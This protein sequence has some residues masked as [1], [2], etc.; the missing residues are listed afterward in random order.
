[1][2][3]LRNVVV[4]L[5]CSQEVAANIERGTDPAD[6]AVQALAWR[7]RDVMQEMTDGD[8]DG[9]A[10]VYSKIEG[11]GPQAATRGILSAE[12]WE[13]L[14]RAFAVGFGSPP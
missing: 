2:V 5:R 9:L 14:K 4:P 12:V 10:S 8:P 7:W 3:P 6:P 13:Y 1:V 11:K